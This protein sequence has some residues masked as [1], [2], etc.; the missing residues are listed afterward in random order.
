MI[1]TGA[2]LTLRT[3]SAAGAAPINSAVFSQ[4]GSFDLV[5]FSFVL[6]EN[7]AALHDTQF[8]FLR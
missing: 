1:V 3:W 4:S 8:V 6:A 5:L 2:T 7:A